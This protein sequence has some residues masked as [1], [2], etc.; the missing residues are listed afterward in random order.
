VYYDAAD[1]T[2]QRELLGYNQLRGSGLPS[3]DV[4]QSNQV[5]YVKTR[6]QSAWTAVEAN[7]THHQST[8]IC[9]LG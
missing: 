8:I 9:Q 6:L 2:E 1:G 3:R 7:D 4:N 5:F